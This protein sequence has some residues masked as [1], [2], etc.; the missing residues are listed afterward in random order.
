M[1]LS[2]IIDRSGRRVANDAGT[3]A[4]EEEEEEKGKVVVAVLPVVTTLRLRLRLGGDGC[5]M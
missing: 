2:G 3:K 1:E 5:M 4:D